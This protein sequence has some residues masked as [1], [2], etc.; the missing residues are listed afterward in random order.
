MAPAPA[1][2]AIR[3]VSAGHMLIDVE[4]PTG[5]QDAAYSSERR[6]RVGDGTEDQVH[7]DRI[8]TLA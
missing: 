8:E 1:R 2:S 3:D 6:G 5:F 4:K 7:N